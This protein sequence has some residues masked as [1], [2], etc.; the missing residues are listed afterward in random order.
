[1]HRVGRTARM[2]RAGSALVLLMPHEVTYVDFLR[3]RKVGALWGVCTGTA[4]TALWHM[5]GSAGQ[6]Y[7]YTGRAGDAWHARCDII[8][9]GGT[10]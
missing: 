5:G 4:G 2:G 9:T 3:L 1:M 8:L 7:L 6:G 10:G